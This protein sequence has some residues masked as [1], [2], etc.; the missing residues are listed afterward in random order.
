MS[1]KNQRVTPISEVARRRFSNWK[2][3]LFLLAVTVAA[4]ELINAAC[5]VDELLLT[6]E[7][8]VRRR[9]DFKLNQRIGNAIDF[10]SF[11]G[12][13]CRAGDENLFVRH[14]LEYYFAVV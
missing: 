4:H 10:D 1:K 13:D 8:G 2:K 9:G 3:R 5:S 11:L 7:E 6:G 14:V 12:C